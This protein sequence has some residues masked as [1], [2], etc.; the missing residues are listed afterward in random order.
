MTREFLYL[1]RY[2][3]RYRKALERGRTCGQA[4]PGV[5]H[6]MDSGAAV[7]NLNEGEEGKRKLFPTT[8]TP[9]YLPHSDNNESSAE[10]KE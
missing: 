3:F 1:Y 4:T 10:I 7:A 8:L 2:S 6:D 9:Q 5:K